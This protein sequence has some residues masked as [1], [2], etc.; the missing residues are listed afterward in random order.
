MRIK[1]R[2]VPGLCLLLV[3]A[4][5]LAGCLQLHQ[6]EVRLGDDPLLAFGNPSGAFTSDPNNY[7]LRRSSFILSYNNAR[8][9]ANWVAW[10]TT[11]ADLGENIPRP[12]FAPDENLPAWFTKIFP[13][14]YS[15]SGYDRGHMVPSADRFGYPA[16]NAETFLMTNIVPQT[17][18]LNQFVW[19]KLER[20]ERSIVRRGS[21]VYVIAGIAGEQ[22]RIR[23]KVAIPARC[24]KIIVVLPPGSS[25]IDANTRVIA[26]DIPNTGGIASDNWRKYLTTVRLIEQRTGYDFFSSVPP[27]IQELETRTD[28]RSRLDRDE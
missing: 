23:G 25:E 20:Y 19:E 8:G 26:V 12:D 9:T 6:P 27:E 10:R 15:G 18:D 13:G 4:C 17:R 21:D 14:D 11:V 7:L 28:E 22:G 2:R 3:A 24:W 5:L 16:A 1:L